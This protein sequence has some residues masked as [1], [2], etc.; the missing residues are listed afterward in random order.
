MT[1]WEGGKE[2]GGEE[3]MFFGDLYVMMP[4]KE[5]SEMLELIAR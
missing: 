5:R 4:M 3:K 2:G 1:T